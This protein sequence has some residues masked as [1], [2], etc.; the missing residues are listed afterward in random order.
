M[1]K[2]DAKAKVEPVISVSR[3]KTELVSARPLAQIK[4]WRAMFDLVPD[5]S[6]EPITI[7][8]FLRTQGQPLTETWLYQWV[9]PA[10]PDRKLY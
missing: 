1:P 2:L 4:G 7:R 10:V 6:V 9:P 3:G 5:A 8:M